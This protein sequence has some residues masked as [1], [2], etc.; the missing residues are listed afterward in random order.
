LEARYLFLG[1][2]AFTVDLAGPLEPTLV[3]PFPALTAAIRVSALNI[4]AARRALWV[5][6]RWLTRRFISFAVFVPCIG[7]P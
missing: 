4:S 7:H 6:L 3:L 1:L 5:A 2:V